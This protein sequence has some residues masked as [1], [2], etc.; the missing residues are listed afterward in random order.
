MTNSFIDLKAL[1][2]E[3]LMIEHLFSAEIEP[4]KQG[5]IQLNFNPPHIFRDIMEFMLP[6]EN[7]ASPRKL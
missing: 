4:F 2:G 1:S 7:N 3:E 5:Y 6:K